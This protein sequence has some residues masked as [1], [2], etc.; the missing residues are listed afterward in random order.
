MIF[1]MRCLKAK[2]Y[3]KERE[4]PDLNDVVVWKD[5]KLPY[6]LEV[7]CEIHSERDVHTFHAIVTIRWGE[8]ESAC[9]QFCYH[10]H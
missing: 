8:Q 9:Q 4:L 2:K 5:F 1:G 10:P 7:V 3:T 6:V